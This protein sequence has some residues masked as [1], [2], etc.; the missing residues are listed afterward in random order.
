MTAKAMAG[1]E[2]SMDSV[3]RSPPGTIVRVATVAA[4]AGAIVGLQL[5]AREGID[6]V[7]VAQE[8]DVGEPRARRGGHVLRRPASGPARRSRPPLR[9]SRRPSPSPE[10]SGRKQARPVAG[11]HLHLVAAAGLDARTRRPCARPCSRSPPP[12]RP[13]SSG[14]PR[15]CRPFRR[16]TLKLV[17]RRLEAQGRGVHAHAGGVGH[18]P[19]RCRPG[20]AARTRRWAGAAAVRGQGPV[21]RHGRA[22]LEHRAA[23]V[24]QQPAQLALRGVRVRG[25]SRPRPRPRP[26]A[27]PPAGCRLTVKVE[28]RSGRTVIWRAGAGR[29]PAARARSV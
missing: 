10:T 8:A 16:T 20:P 2:P 25:R 3:S 7:A 28:S 1:A 27:R 9:L 24:A 5:E 15:P 11:A 22:G 26:P 6:V 13:G 12:G 4:H 29:W 18:A 17:G 21:R 14:R 19:R 23:L